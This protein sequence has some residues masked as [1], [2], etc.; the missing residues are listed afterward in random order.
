[1]ICWG[2][3]ETR[4]F[5]LAAVGGPHAWGSLIV[6]LWDGETFSPGSA[7]EAI[8]QVQVHENAKQI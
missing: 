3:F 5:N 4:A 1:M 8:D 2:Q 7:D 6:R